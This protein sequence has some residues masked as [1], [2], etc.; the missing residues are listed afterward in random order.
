VIVAVAQIWG[1]F[2]FRHQKVWVKTTHR[3]NAPHEGCLY[4]ARAESSGRALNT[5]ENSYPV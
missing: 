5:A 2:R 1:L 4:D 3:I